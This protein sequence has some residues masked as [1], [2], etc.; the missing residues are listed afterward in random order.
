MF[1]RN[2]QTH[3][4]SWGPGGSRPPSFMRDLREPCSGVLSAAFTAG[5]TQ[6]RP[7]PHLGVVGFVFRSFD[8][9]CCLLLLTFAPFCSHES[10]AQ[11]LDK[12]QLLD[13]ELLSTSGVPICPSF[14]C[15]SPD[16][17]HGCR[18]LCR[19]PGPFPTLLRP[20]QAGP[21]WGRCRPRV[22]AQWRG[23]RHL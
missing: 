6:A 21:A 2:L 16:T 8:G 12:A 17:T 4:G 18:P 23:G 19:C 10:L 20:L 14:F 13:I 5:P 22:S 3:H 11:A 15:G 7:G 9:P 1:P